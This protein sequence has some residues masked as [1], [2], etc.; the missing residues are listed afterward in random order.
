M[1]DFH[2]NGGNGG[3]GD[4]MD[5]NSISIAEM[6]DNDMRSLFN[7]PLSGVESME[8]LS[9]LEASE[10][11]FKAVQPQQGVAAAGPLHVWSS[12]AGGSESYTSS[13][14]GGFSNVN[15]LE[16]M[17]V[18]VNP[19]NVM[20]VGSTQQQSQ[21][22]QRLQQVQ[23]LSENTQFSLQSVGQMSPQVASPVYMAQQPKQQ[24][25]VQ[26]QQPQQH[27]YAVRTGHAGQP[28]KALKVLPPSSSPM[29]RVPGSPG[30]SSAPYPVVNPTRKK[31]HSAK[32]QNGGEKENGFP[33]PPYS[34]S[35]LIALALKN[36]H[37]GSMSVSEIYKFMW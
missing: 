16:D 37:S 9:G 20:P 35:C 27:V 8:L 31:N 7:D 29:Q 3:G 6:V 17:G 4:L 18:M 32:S 28:S 13:S 5:L 25:L 21:E 24:Q 12:S 19:N 10:D 34:Y 26:H 2:G 36:S 11:L 33:K 15:Y 14:L 22:P 30:S 23:G 1:D